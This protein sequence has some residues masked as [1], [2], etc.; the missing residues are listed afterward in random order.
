VATF[1]KDIFSTFSQ[2]IKRK[3]GHNSTTNQN[4][5]KLKKIYFKNFDADFPRL[6]KGHFLFHEFGPKFHL[7]DKALSMLTLPLP[8]HTSLLC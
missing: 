7:Q 2:Q 6:E 8:E 3:N 4:R 1:A 5:G